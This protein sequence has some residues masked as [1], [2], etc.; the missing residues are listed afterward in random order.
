LFVLRKNASQNPA[1]GLRSWRRPAV[2]GGA[3]IALIAASALAVGVS[4]SPSMAAVNVVS[5]I[6]GQPAASAPV[7]TVTGPIAG[8]LPSQ[9][10]GGVVP[11]STPVL[12]AN[13]YQQ[14]EFFVAGS[15]SAYNFVG[16]PGT[17]GRWTV[18]VVPGSAA[19]Y[20]TRIEVFSPTNRSRF[21]GHVLMEWDNV[22]AGTDAAPDLTMSHPNV[23]R[24]GDVYIG[25]SAQFVGVESAALSNPS[26]Y[27]SLVHPGDSY[28][29]DIFSQ[30]GMAIRGRSAQILPGLAPRDVLALGESQSAFALTTY[31][32]AFAPISHVYD[33]Y[34]I[35][36][37]TTA[38]LP[39]QEAPAPASVLVNGVPTTEPDGNTGLTTV[40]TPPIVQ[41]RTDLL[42]PV[43]TYLT[44][45]DVYAPPNGLL[46]YG[47]A[48][49]AD[50]ADFR[51]WE[52]AGTAHADDCLV[53]LCANDKGDAA[54][55]RSR[56]NDMLTPPTNF[57][58]LANC[59]API[60]TGEMGY[61]LG[62]A[63]DQLSLWTATGGVP[64]GIPASSVPLFAGQSVGE[65]FT[66]VPVLDAVGNI[67]G[68][69]RSPAVDV[70]VATL[71]GVVNSP[72]FC[73]FSGTTTAFTAAQL[74]AHYPTHAAFVN[75]WSVDVANLVARRFLAPADGVN[76]VL[77]AQAS[78]VPAT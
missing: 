72:G 21:S 78:T 25:V 47:P 77:A 35:N 64:K 71:T 23:F 54:G 7:P 31:V 14:T 37:R 65:G 42:S 50:S 59:D 1:G 53:N 20:K 76:L 36:S 69:L 39:L 46:S 2:S 56:F 75:A 19:A 55:A 49:Q 43:L 26:R 41:T 9:V 27:G 57:G 60:N 66:T 51:L 44:Q 61:T 62:A 38:G 34:L 33:G 15:A 32:D 12:T 74:V 18:S 16:T 6:P 22:T 5:P 11:V 28:S 45:T 40:N 17:D 29:Y 73:V 10:N 63:M 13:G 3:L 52:V 8:P 30:A 4:A 67:V 24:D 48:T 70:P 58:G 68:G